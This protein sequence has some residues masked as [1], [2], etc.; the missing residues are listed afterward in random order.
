MDKMSYITSHE[1]IFL[2]KLKKDFNEKKDKSFFRLLFLGDELRELNNTE[3]KEKIHQNI[4]K[5]SKNNHPYHY[6]ITHTQW[7]SEM[8]GQC[9]L[10][11]YKDHFIIADSQYH[12]YSIG[13]EI[14]NIPLYMLPPSIQK[15]DKSE[16]KVQI[17]ENDQI[18]YNLILLEYRNFCKEMGMNFAKDIQYVKNQ[19]DEFEQLLA[20]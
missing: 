9:F 10:G 20:K 12:L 2:F 17:K 15:L 4:I 3:L 19:A 14:Q 1:M 6:Q 8:I 11:K 13:K 5:P 16:L 18:D 7:I